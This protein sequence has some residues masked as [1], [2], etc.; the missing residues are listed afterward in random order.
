MSFD[1]NQYYPDSGKTLE[2]LGYEGP[3]LEI[4][5]AAMESPVGLVVVAGISGSDPHD[6]LYG[7]LRLATRH[8]SGRKVER[9]GGSWDYPN[10]GLALGAGSPSDANSFRRSMLYA[11]RGDPDLLMVG[12]VRDLESAQTLQS[13]VQSGHKALTTIHASSAFSI[14]Q[15]LARL[16]YEFTAD[17]DILEMSALVYQAKIPSL[18]SH[19]SVDFEQAKK[20]SMDW[21]DFQAQRFETFVTPDLLARLRFKN[22]SGCQH[23]NGGVVGKTTVAEAITPDETLL[24]L[25]IEGRELEALE[26]HRKLGGRTIL[27]AAISKAI[28]GIVDLRDIEL[29]VDLLAHYVVLENGESRLQ[30]EYPPEYFIAT[31]SITLPGQAFDTIE[32]THTEQI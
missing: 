22:H 26:Y 25:L 28:R 8:A 1:F 32:K 15:R 7:C 4:L 6:T 24:R 16:G 30:Y 27:E 5:Q 23:C 20:C 12:E 2:E 10:S 13:V 21:S 18:C 14:I 31:P 29:R 19:C 3:E 9:V 17:M 11:L